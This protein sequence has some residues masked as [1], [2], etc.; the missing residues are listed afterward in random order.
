MSWRDRSFEPVIIANI[1][2]IGEDLC[3]KMKPIFL[4]FCIFAAV[5]LSGCREENDETA[6]L[7][8]ESIE[9]EPMHGTEGKFE[10][11]KVNGTSDEPSFPVG[12]GRHYLV[13]FLDDSI[14]FNG[15]KYRMTATHVETDETIELY[16]AGIDGNRSGA[17]FVLGK[18]GM[19]KVDVFIDEERLTSFEIEAE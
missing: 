9:K 10:I 3:V 11:V 19:W 13:C 7:G 14:D 17:K 6:M 16:E 4:M 12:E 8:A 5:C 15:K 1:Q 18:A 2:P